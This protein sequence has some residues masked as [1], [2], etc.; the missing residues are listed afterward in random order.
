[1][2]PSLSAYWALF[3]GTA[4]VHNTLVSMHSLDGYF[5]CILPSPP[6]PDPQKGGRA[7]RWTGKVSARTRN[8]LYCLSMPLNLPCVHLYPRKGKSIIY[9]LYLPACGKKEF[10]QI[11][12]SFRLHSQTLFILC[13]WP[14][15]GLG[16]INNLFQALLYF[17]T[18]SVSDLAAPVKALI[19]S[20]S[21]LC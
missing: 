14:V 18:N 2:F 17:L 7:G 16:A 4:A 5:L 11:F 13:G 3:S 20:V 6:S 15:Q 10:F 8:S 1:M 21:C 12:H 9:T 19:R